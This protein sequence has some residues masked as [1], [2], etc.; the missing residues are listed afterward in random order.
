MIG[1]VTFRSERGPWEVSYALRADRWGA[2]FGY[3]AVTLAIAWF[4]RELGATALIAVTQLNNERS[5]RLLT[6]LGGTALNVFEEYG[7]SQVRYALPTASGMPYQLAAATDR[8]RASA[9]I[10]ADKPQG[11]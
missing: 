11:R 1:T 4:R 6:R 8:V 9:R 3:E 2:G 10:A 7:R 5:R